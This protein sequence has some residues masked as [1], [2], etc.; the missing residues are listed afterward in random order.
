MP[1]FFLP[2]DSAAPAP[3]AVRELPRSPIPA[4]LKPGS[5]STPIGDAAVI[6]YEPAAAANWPSPTPYQVAQALDDLAA[7]GGTSALPATAA[8]VVGGQTYT[9]KS[10]DRAIRVDSSNGLQPVINLVAIPIGQRITIYWWNWATG[11]GQPVGPVVNAPS[12]V[13]M[14]TFI[15]QAVAGN[16]GLA[17]TS[18]VT[19]PGATYTLLWDGTELCSV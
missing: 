5:T 10:T 15:G 13:L 9:C 18:T 4:A 11:A 16:A 7:A 3:G 1:G 12:G 8:T 6:Q 17:S 14:Q 2:P 19:T